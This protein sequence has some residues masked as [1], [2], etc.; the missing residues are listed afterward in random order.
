MKIAFLSLYSGIVA[1]GAETF[2]QELAN[3]L[4]TLGNDVVVY[5]GGDRIV[6]SKYKTVTIKMNID[7]S[8]KRSDIPFINY[9]SLRVKNFTDKVLNYIDRDTQIIFPTNGQWQ[10]LLCS[11][12]AKRN[13]RKIIIS[14]QS[15]PGMDD[16]INILTFPN[17]FVGL[18]KYQSDWAKKAN[19]FVKIETIPN[20]VDLEKFT[21]GGRPIKLDIK[22]PIILCVAALQ[23]WKRL[24][25]AIKAVAKLKKVS[26]VLVG[27][28]D[29]KEFLENLGKKLLP[30]RFKIINFDHKDM[31]A[32]YK[33]ADLFTFPTVP[34]ESFGIVLVEAMASGLPVVATNDPIRKEIVGNA[35]ILVDPT[36][37]D[38]YSKT[39]QKALDI[40]WGDIP[41]K[42]A[43][44]FSWEA[45]AEQ[46]EE[47]FKT[48]KK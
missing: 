6:G 31:P 43:E 32:V 2:V 47:L 24:D 36:N 14:G 5:Q 7:W 18:T 3:A 13:K 28:G 46:Y 15:G 21:I 25:L 9:Y 37:I 38:E 48:L 10:S 1:R 22:K 27:K 45:I 40:N 33:S 17:V 29:Q 34:W 26:L 20:G 16:R 41:R 23:N 39:L 8:K 42:Q 30:N 44:R 4:V 35:G 11:I 12:W 19:K